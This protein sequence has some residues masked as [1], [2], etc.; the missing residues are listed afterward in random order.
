V[1][2]IEELSD[3]KTRVVGSKQVMK[4]ASIAKFDKVF[5]ASD[6]DEALKQKLKKTCETHSIK[7]DM[8]HTMQQIGKACNIEV[9][10][11]CAAI[12]RQ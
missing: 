10:S 1:G 6:A 3:V 5:I 11:A 7:Y 8:S 4:Y 2:I 12:K 9:K